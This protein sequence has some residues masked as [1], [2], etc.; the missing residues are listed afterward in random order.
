ME[1]AS[2]EKAPQ[3]K[4]RPE[5][6]RGV[7][8]WLGCAAPQGGAFE[9]GSPWAVFVKPAR[10]LLATPDLAEPAPLGA[11]ACSLSLGATLAL[12][13]RARLLDPSGGSSE[14]VKEER[15]SPGP[16]STPHPPAHYLDHH[17][18]SLIQSSGV[19]FNRSLEGKTGRGMIVAS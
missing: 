18:Q 7:G 12:Q 15:S 1:G 5:T 14:A 6:A 16:V 9:P 2:A 17:L 8:R 3:T 19:H 10:P 11:R 13:L 4:P